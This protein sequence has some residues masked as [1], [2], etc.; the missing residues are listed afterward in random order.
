MKEYFF[1][2]ILKRL[3]LIIAV[4]AFIAWVKPALST[5]LISPSH[6]YVDN[7]GD[8]IN[9]LDQRDE[10]DEDKSADPEIRAKIYGV[11]FPIAE[12]GNCQNY[13]ECRSYCED[14]VNAS[15][16]ID[17]GKKKGF[18]KQSLPSDDGKDEL[19]MKAKTQL[20]CDSY[21]SCRS[22][23]QMPANFD[24]CDA[25]AKSSGM[26]G[27]H[28]ND[29][30][31]E[32][33][34]AK[35]NEVLGCDSY[36][37][38]ASFCSDDGNREKCT[39]FA[40][41]TGLRGGERPV[42]PGGCTSEDSCKTFCSDPQNFQVCQ[43][44][45]SSS[46]GKFSGPG[47]CNSES[48]CRDYCQGNPD[49]C[50]NFAAQSGGGDT[51]R[52]YCDENPDKC[53]QD[54]DED[55][56]EFEK[57]CLKN[58]D[59][60]REIEEEHKRKG[61]DP[62]EMCFRTPSCKW[63]ENTCKC[64]FYVRSEPVTEKS[65]AEEYAKFCRENPDKCGSG[66]RGGFDDKQE[67]RDFEEECRRNPARCMIYDRGGSGSNPASTTAPV[68]ASGGLPGTNM[69]R[70]TQEAGCRSCGGTCNWNG[71]MCQC[72]C[73]N[74]GSSGGGGSALTPAPVQESAPAP[75]PAQQTTTTS[76]GGS[77]SSD[78]SGGGGSCPQGS[79]MKDGACVSGVQGVSTAR[80]WLDRIS[81]SWR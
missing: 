65:R 35:A 14:P 13:Y 49:S 17:Y 66:Q 51:Y 12:L 2:Y 22:F 59:K 69:S 19:I 78:Y 8:G 52:K 81:D 26:T 33:I 53:R 21:E 62:K 31:K 73:A 63:E 18:Y 72:Q 5:V 74:S 32:I 16:C 40:K 41:E 58:P 80:S 38:C 36:A 56:R 23:C 28:V 47:G 60:C 48:S 50:R 44:F 20:G 75:Q 30:K 43:G 61:Y 42:G 27:G 57:Y 4:F 24:K 64:G 55:K 54:R 37:S 70:E 10:D 45:M 11:T 25:F 15:A 67:R 68:P 39:A 3:L 46:G 7:N 1:N 34:M 71:D 77:G 79:Y 6:P 9:D 29:A 76:S